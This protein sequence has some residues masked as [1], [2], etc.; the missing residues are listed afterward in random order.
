MAGQI[1]RSLGAG[2]ILVRV[3]DPVRCDIFGQMGLETLSPTVDGARRLFA[4]VVDQAEE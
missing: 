1:A 4:M 3:Y 2:R